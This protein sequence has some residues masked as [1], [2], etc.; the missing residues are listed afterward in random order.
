[1]EAPLP[2]NA[3]IHRAYSYLLGLY[4]GDGYLVRFPRAW[5]LR[6]LFDAR[7]PNYAFTNMSADIR[8]IFCD[9]LDLLGISWRRAGA[10][11]IAIARREAVAALDA[12]VGPKA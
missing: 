3:E 10:R 9:H 1:V 7:Y 4:L 6:I 12:F 8:A 11:N 5:C 2:E